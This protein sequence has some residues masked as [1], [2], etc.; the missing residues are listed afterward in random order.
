MYNRPGGR[1]HAFKDPLVASTIEHNRR[2]MRSGGVSMLAVV[3][4]FKLLM[5]LSIG[6]FQLLKFVWSRVGKRSRSKSDVIDS[7]SDGIQYKVFDPDS[8][9]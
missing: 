5:F 2:T 9:D 3:G 4:M 6:A 7:S 1:G 8:D